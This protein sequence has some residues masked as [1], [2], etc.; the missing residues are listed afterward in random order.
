MDEHTEKFIDEFI[1]HISRAKIAAEREFISANSVMI[2]EDI[3]KSFFP[4]FEQGPL[5]TTEDGGAS[6]HFEF[7]GAA[8]TICGL[9]AVPGNLESFPK[10]TAFVVYE[11]IDESKSVWIS[12]EDKLP[13]DMDLDWVL[14]CV[15]EDNGYKWP[16]PKV[17]EYRKSY[18]DWYVEGVG[19]LQNTHK[20]CFAVTHW[21]P[22]PELPKE[23]EA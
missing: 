17:A 6:I 23:V 5:K 13:S 7:A 14:A 12:V 19:W 8:L 10:N 1:D 22:L 2:D 21:M 9:R 11:G 16:I 20:G 3:Y 18:D 15:V 4:F